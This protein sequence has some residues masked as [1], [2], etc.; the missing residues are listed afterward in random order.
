VARGALVDDAAG[1]DL[2]RRE[3]GRGPVPNIVVRSLLGR[4][5]PTRRIGW[6]RSKAW[7]WDFS[8]TQTTTARSGGCR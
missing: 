7:I 8:S 5:S 2:Q 6:V 4:S 3:Q 1:R